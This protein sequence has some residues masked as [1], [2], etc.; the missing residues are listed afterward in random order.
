MNGSSGAVEKLSPGVQIAAGN[1]RDEDGVNSE[2]LLPEVLAEK[3]KLVSRG[4]S[5]F[6]LF[7]IALILIQ[8]EA[9]VQD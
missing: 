9:Q 4:R 6:H 1:V 3:S 7:L 8:H 2:L 5:F